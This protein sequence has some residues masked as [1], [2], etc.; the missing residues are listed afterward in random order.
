MPGPLKAD[1]LLASSRPAPLGPF[2]SCPLP[3]LLPAS[4]WHTVLRLL[5]VVF[6]CLVCLFS[7]NT[8]HECRHM[9]RLPRLAGLTAS[10]C[11]PPAPSTLAD[12]SLYELGLHCAS[13]CLDFASSLCLLGSTLVVSG[14]W[15]LPVILPSAWGFLDLSSACFPHFCG[16]NPLGAAESLLSAVLTSR[17][18]LGI[19][20]GSPACNTLSSLGCFG[21]L[22]LGPES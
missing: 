9:V 12:G 20:P 7:L 8:A 21:I 16:L 14:S 19:A 2:P 18:M 17:V 4:N 1:S 10:S 15:L 5:V 3:S 13:L 22:G 11:S 6:I